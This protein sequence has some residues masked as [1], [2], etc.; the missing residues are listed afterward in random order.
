[1]LQRQKLAWDA[2][3]KAE[4]SRK[5]KLRLDQEDAEVTAR[6]KSIDT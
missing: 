1:M 4:W 5:R 3:L 2:Q 6:Y